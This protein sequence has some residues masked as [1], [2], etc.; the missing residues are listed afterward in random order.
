MDDS[1]KNAPSVKNTSK[2]KKGKRFINFVD[3]IIFILIVSI[4]V[5]GVMAFLGML[6]N[7]VTTEIEYTICFSN[8]P[9]ELINKIKIGNSA[10]DAVS[11][12]DLGS[13]EDINNT[14]KYF[15][16]GIDKDTQAPVIIT[17]T[18]RY[19]VYVT[20][21]STAV[22]AEGE[23]YTVNGSRIAVG[24]EFSVR[25]PA[26]SGSGYCTQMKEVEGQ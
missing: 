7:D 11:K 18:D 22:Y 4:V 5:L 26:Y 1:I 16:Y 6:D 19:N 9:S 21:R 17:F 10:I 15:E 2:K 25:F 13:V 24:K 12:C 3:I 20:I 8:V 14:E 23:G